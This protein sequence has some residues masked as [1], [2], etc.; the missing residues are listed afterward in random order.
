MSPIGPSA[1]IAATPHFVRLR[2]EWLARHERRAD[3]VAR[4]PAT[5][6]MKHVAA[7]NLEAQLFGLG[8]LVQLVKRARHAATTRELPRVAA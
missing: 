4:K 8:T 1:A 2:G 5:D 3:G 6:P 7:S